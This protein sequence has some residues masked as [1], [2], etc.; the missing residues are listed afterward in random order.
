M[1][2]VEEISQQKNVSEDLKNISASNLKSLLNKLFNLADYEK[3]VMIMDEISKRE[4]KTLLLLF[5]EN[6]LMLTAHLYYH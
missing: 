4:N 1:D 3:A 5:F 2:V 6:Y